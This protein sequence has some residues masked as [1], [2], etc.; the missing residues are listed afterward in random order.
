MPRRTPIQLALLA[1]GL[2]AWAYGQRIDDARLTYVG[3][4]FFAT[5]FLLRFFKPRDPPATS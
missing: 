2:I 5:A 3:V 4:A 1:V